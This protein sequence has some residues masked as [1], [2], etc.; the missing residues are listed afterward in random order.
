MANA[1]E[2]RR[3]R[4]QD[5]RRVAREAPAEDASVTRPA[6]R[7]EVVS[8]ATGSAVREEPSG[9][10]EEPVVAGE[11]LAEGHDADGRPPADPAHDY[12]DDL[13]RLQAEFD[14]YRKRVVREQTALTERATER[15]VERLLPVLDNFER[16]LGHGVAA[17]GVELVYRQLRDLLAQEGLEEVPAEDVV[18]DPAVHEAVELSEREGVTE[19]TCTSVLRRGYRIGGRL[20]RPAMVTVARPPEEPGDP[21]KDVDE[22]RAVAGNG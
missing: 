18:F 10:A 19:P 21:R 4:V 17:E 22:D 6:G 8:D 11:P 7:G 12:L 2:P 14:N 20:L 15:L 16:A 13:R 5:K 1:S 9:R 3:I